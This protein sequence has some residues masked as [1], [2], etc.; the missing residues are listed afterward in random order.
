VG[1][2]IDAPPRQVWRQLEDVG[3]HV[4]WMHDAVAIRFRGAQRRGVG[5][6]FDCDTRLGPFQLVD[7]MVITEWR[8]R[9]AMGVRHQGAVSGTGRFTLRARPRGRTRFTW[10]EE[11]TFPWWLGGPVGAVLGGEVLRLV[12]ARNLRNLKA[13]VEGR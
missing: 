12:W 6:S 5:T 3:S 13:L 11:L 2:T 10:R 1:I 8:P 7:R 9:R 4:R